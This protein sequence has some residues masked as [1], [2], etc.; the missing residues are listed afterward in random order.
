MRGINEHFTLRFKIEPCRNQDMDI[1]HRKLI[2]EKEEAE[3]DKKRKRKRNLQLPQEKLNDEEEATSQNQK[4]AAQLEEEE[5]RKKQKLEEE[6]KDK[7]VKE[8]LKQGHE[9]L[10]LS[11]LG[12]GYI[13]LAKPIV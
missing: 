2:E 11:C 13:N 1:N 7:S 5:K 12:L 3:L 4:T 8:Y 9:K 6:E 10:L